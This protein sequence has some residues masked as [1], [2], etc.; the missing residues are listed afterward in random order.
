MKA[1]YKLMLGPGSVHA[2][3]ALAGGFIGAD[4]GIEQDL[5]GHLPDDFKRFSEEFIPVYLAGHPGKGRIAAGLACGA[6][7]TVSRGMN[8]GDLLLS[9]DGA[10]Q[11]VVGE[12]AGGYS[13]VPD[14]PLPHRRAIKWRDQRINKAD[15]GDTLKKAMGAIQAVINL[16]S[17]R[18]EI[19]A[20]VAGSAPPIIVS[21]DAAVEDPA[22]FVMESHL[23][24]FLVQN[25]AHTALGKA[26]DI[27]QDE[28]QAVGQQF[29]T[30]TGPMD[31]LAI[32]KDKKTLLVVE[33]KKGRAS[34]AVVGQTLR[35]MGYVQSVLAE[36]GQQVIGAIV[37]LEDDMRIRRALS[38]T[39]SITFYRYEIKFELIKGDG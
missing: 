21:T 34:D 5:T 32:S 38:M 10:G 11:Y 12:I 36:A 17:H 6:L 23:E 2:A 26:F 33:L 25:W 13:F 35:Y 37:A 9:P 18:D 8:V 1:Y 4:Y 20:L 39:P 27:F 15:V 30:D 31:V 28:G 14:G 29:M 7:W 24:E 19:D 16:T 22:L 3:E